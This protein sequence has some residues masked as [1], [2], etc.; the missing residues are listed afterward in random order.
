MALPNAAY[1][2]VA[3]S[4]LSKK[5]VIASS[6]TAFG[7]NA[8]LRVFRVGVPQ[9]NRIPPTRVFRIRDDSYREVALTGLSRNAV[10]RESSAAAVSATISLGA[11]F[12]GGVG[13]PGNF[14]AAITLGA[15]FDGTVTHGTAHSAVVSTTITVGA[16]FDGTVTSG[17]AHSGVVSTTITFGAAFDGTLTEAVSTLDALLTQAALETAGG[18]GAAQSAAVVTQTAVE[19][20]AA[21]HDP[22]DN[23]LATQAAVE[24]AAAQY[25]PNDN[26]L[27]T[28]AALEVVGKYVRPST[29]KAYIEGSCPQDIGSFI[30]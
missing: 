14:A 10:I 22:N 30:Y 13:V 18:A 12:A 15:A 25:D 26:L 21:Q 29:P 1:A 19:I 16:T 8:P 11:T 3:L 5:A 24:I 6:G 7:N 28:Q 4:G 2:E 9:W 20:A 17:T 23:V 27:L